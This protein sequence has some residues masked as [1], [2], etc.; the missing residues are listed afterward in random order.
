MA[1][2]HPRL[3]T[4][5]ASFERYV[6]LP[7]HMVKTPAWKKM[8]PEAKALYVDVAER[9]NGHN[10]G[11]I[12]YSVREAAAICLSPATA[13]RMFK[14]LVERG[15]LRIAQD[16]SFNTKAFHLARLWTL[17]AWPLDDVRGE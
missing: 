2:K 15:F 6:G 16:A 1:R 11:Q 3:A 17:T 14:I 8:K 12:S 5:T 13:S 7:H 10:N 9:Y 4:K